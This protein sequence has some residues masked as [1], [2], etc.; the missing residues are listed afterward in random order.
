MATFRLVAGM[1]WT[2]FRGLPCNEITQGFG[3]A[4][5]PDPKHTASTLVLPSIGSK[6]CGSK[7]FSVLQASR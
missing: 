4:A 1:A 2:S 6:A 3:A 7:R 5:I